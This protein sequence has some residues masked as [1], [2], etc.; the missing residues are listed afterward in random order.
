MNLEIYEFIKFR[1]TK[2][3]SLKTKQYNSRIKFVN[4]KK[5]NIN[6]LTF[7][8]Q[9]KLRAKTIKLDKSNEQRCLQIIQKTNQFNLTTKRYDLAKIREFHRNKN[10]H[11][12]MVDLN[13]KYGK[14]GLVALVMLRKEKNFIYIDNFAMSCR[15]L[16]RHLELWIISKVVEYAKKNKVEYIIGEYVPTKKNILVKDLYSKMGFKKIIKKKETPVNLGKY[17]SQKSNMLISDIKNINVIN[18]KIYLN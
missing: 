10:N 18:S 7:L 5:R 14:H 3:D 1:I 8:K 11:M 9:I 2:E 16:G 15:V 12:F 6:E 13:D 4:E 17:L